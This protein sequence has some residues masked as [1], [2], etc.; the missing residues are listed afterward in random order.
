[1]L[2][3]VQN[4]EVAHGPQILPGG[5]AVLF[6]LAPS[7]AAADWD[8]AQILV[9][10]LKSG[11]RTPLIDTGSDGR[12]LPTGEIVYAFSGTLFA[13]PFDLQRLKVTGGQVPVVEGVRRAGGTGTAQFSFSD[14]GTLIYV[15]GPVVATG[16]Q[17][18]LALMDRKGVL[19]I[20]KMPPRAYGFPRVSPDGKR[21]AFGIDE[22]KDTNVWVYDLAGNSA[23]RQL[24]VGGANRYPV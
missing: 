17:S 22:G 20:R 14:T 12:Y 2:V 24:T 16:L 21:I 7:A 15:P 4:N 18:V 5:K 23:I 19:D 3:R 10:T 11:E 13:V 1:L 8:K 9:Q 6:T